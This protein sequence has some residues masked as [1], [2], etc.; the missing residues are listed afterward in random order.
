MG[1]TRL[2]MYLYF[3]FTIN[4]YY[5]KTFRFY[6]ISLI[7]LLSMKSFSAGNSGAIYFTDDFSDPGLWLSQGAG[8]VFVG[9][10]VCNFNNVYDGVYNRVYQSMAQ[11]LNSSNWRAECDFT[12]LNPNPEGHGTGE[13]VLALTAGSLDFMSYDSS[14]YYQET[15][16]DGVGVV[17]YS[18]YSTDNNIDNW[19]FMIEAKKGNIRSFNQWMSI[20]ASASIGTYYIRFERYEDGLLRLSIFSDAA[21]KVHLPGS[22]ITYAIDPSIN[23]LTTVQHGSMTPGFYSR[24]INAVVDNDVIYNDDPYLGMAENVRKMNAFQVYPNPA[25][26]AVRVSVPEGFDGSGNYQYSILDMFGREIVTSLFDRSKQID[27]SELVKGVFILVVSGSE[28]RFWTK[29]EKQD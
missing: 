13:V 16:Q 5:M 8:D 19:Y 7:L 15:W 29:F 9:N 24:L 3:L 27:V 21:R 28:K 17:L 6:V 2:F 26:T 11:T 25:T 1:I 12:I 23:R 18:T 22:P 14:L 4:L 10:G 20:P